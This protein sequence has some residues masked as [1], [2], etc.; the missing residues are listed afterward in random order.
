MFMRLRYYWLYLFLM[1]TQLFPSKTP[2]HVIPNGLVMVDRTPFIVGGNLVLLFSNSMFTCEV[3]TSTF[4]F[5]RHV[6]LQRKKK[7]RLYTKNTYKLLRRLFSLK[8]I[9]DAKLNRGLY[10]ALTAYPNKFQNVLTTLYFLTNTYVGLDKR[11]SRLFV[12]YILTLQLYFKQIL[13]VTFCFNMLNTCD[14][15]PSDLQEYGNT[16]LSKITPR[17]LQFYYFRELAD[18]FLSAVYMKNLFFIVRW[19]KYQI[20][21]RPIKLFSL[22]RKFI[23][24]IFKGLFWG[25]R[26]KLN[27]LGFRLNFIG[28]LVKGGGKKRRI[29]IAHGALSHNRKDLRVIYKKFYL[30]TISGIVGCLIEF[31]Y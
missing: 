19:V 3:S 15:L 8:H 13:G 6:F 16:F 10:L 17:K 22:M 7:R 26:Q 12:D 4:I 30:R 24:K 14:L 11:F 29:K 5:K 21:K 28:K 23:R 18:I 31:T 20:E 27:L 2:P 1:R 25:F 9:A